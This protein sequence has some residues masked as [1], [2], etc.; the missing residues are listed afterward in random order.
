MLSY[1]TEYDIIYIC[2]AEIATMSLDSTLELAI[3]VIVASSTQQQSAQD[4]DRQLLIVKHA[5]SFLSK[6]LLLYMNSP[7]A[8]FTFHPCSN[9]QAM[10]WSLTRL[11]RY[12]FSLLDVSYG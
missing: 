10:F 11:R 3:K 8:A 1:D 6:L 7:L 4:G 12:F 5:I 2:F 9:F